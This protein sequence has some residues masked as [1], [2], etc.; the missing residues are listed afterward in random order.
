MWP[1]C[2]HCEH[3]PGVIEEGALNAEHHADPC[4]HCQDPDSIA[5]REAASA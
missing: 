2:E 4:E 3:D 1:C 5:R